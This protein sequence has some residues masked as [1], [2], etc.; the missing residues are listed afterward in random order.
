MKVDYT[1]PAVGTY[2]VDVKASRAG[3]QGSSARGQD[4]AT[5]SGDVALVSKALAAA[6]AEPGI[7]PEAVAR[8]KAIVESNQ[9]LDVEALSDA[10]IDR[11]LESA[12]H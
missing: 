5:L 3:A 6:T 8:G 2:G 1:R 12:D 7:R 11:L 10:L 4:S 9:P